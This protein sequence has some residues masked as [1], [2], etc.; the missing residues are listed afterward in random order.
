MKGHGFRNIEQAL[1][2]IVP[3]R[4]LRRAH[5]QRIAAI[6][7]HGVTSSRAF[8]RQLDALG[9]IGVFIT[10][11]ELRAAIDGESLPENS[12]LLTFDD[13]ERS[14]LDKGLPVIAEF[15]IRPILF[16]CGGLLDGRSPFWWEEAESLANDGIE[17]VRRLKRVPDEERRE[18][19]ATLREQ[20]PAI[21]GNQLTTEEL[22]ALVDA[23]FEI[24]NHTWDHPCLDQCDAPEVERQ[25]AEGHE[26]LVSRG[27]TP[28]AF[29]YPNGNLDPRA[30]P[31]LERLGYDLGFLFDHHHTRLTQPRLRLSRLR[32]DSSASPER[33]RMIVSG[34]H[35]GIM[36][37]R[38]RG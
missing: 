13:G 11:D 2:S 12:I 6:G 5:G 31:A 37:L 14:V 33:A 1:V 4:A 16:V 26:A 25:I 3:D 29:A 9:S 20:G 17:T 32:L 27:I 34:I 38:R 19:L 23:G 21:P 30:E 35:G 22:R 10:P 36:R 15:G 28:T 8:A 18:A 24:G 7:Y